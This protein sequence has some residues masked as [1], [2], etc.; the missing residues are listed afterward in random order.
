MRVPILW[1][2]ITEIMF[3]FHLSWAQ[4]DCAQADSVTALLYLLGDWKDLARIGPCYLSQGCDF[5]Y[6]NVRTGIALF[7]TNRFIGAQK[8]LRKA[9]SQNHNSFVA[10]YLIN[11][12]IRS[13]NHFEARALYRKL[14]P[15]IK[16]TIQLKKKQ[17][18]RSVYLETGTKFSYIH[19]PSMTSYY[20]QLLLTHTLSYSADI[21][22][23]YTVFIRTSPG[24]FL[25]Q[26]Q[27]LINPQL[28][29]GHGWILEV[30]IGIVAYHYKFQNMVVMTYDT[31]YYS[32]VGNTPYTYHYAGIHQRSVRNTQ[33]NISGVFQ[34]IIHKRFSFWN[35]AWGAAVYYS[36]TRT[37]LH[38][39]VVDYGYRDLYINQLWTSRDTLY[40]TVD[41]VLTNRE[42]YLQGLF[43][44]ENY[45]ISPFWNERLSIGCKLFLPIKSQNIYLTA[46]PLVS[47]R[48]R[49]NLWLGASYLYKG[50]Y[51]LIDNSG[52]VVFNNQDVMRARTVISAIY[53]PSQRMHIGL[54]LLFENVSE[55]VTEV[56]G[57]VFSIFAGLKFYL[58]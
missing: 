53:H 19:V 48:V 23:G 30:P 35:T 54:Y 16:K 27:Y 9:L 42:F 12:L 28:Y 18:L 10:G 24:T 37:R 33:S 41:T 6:T 15:E 3:S 46:S 58:P 51:F 31:V 44:W 55:Y 52:S 50:K 56:T 25:H 1:V 57:Q 8:Y 39:V 13:G 26:H 40:Y 45:F 49:D 36:P 21:T 22:H 5:Y 47:V 38:D 2:I 32:Q 11:A 4:E 17:P 29:L 14:H 20:T 34:G 7:N 43:T